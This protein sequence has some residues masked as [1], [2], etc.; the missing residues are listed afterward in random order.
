MV[1]EEVDLVEGDA[2]LFDGATRG[3]VGR[4]EEERILAVVQGERPFRLAV[5]AGDDDVGPAT[6]LSRSSGHKA[7][8]YSFMARA[9]LAPTAHRDFVYEGDVVTYT[10]AVVNVGTYTATNVVL[11]ETLPLYTNYLGIDWMPLNSR[12]F[13]TTLNSLAPGDGR[14]V[15][16][17]VR[18][19]DPIP[20][21]VSNLVNHVCGYSSDQDAHP[22]D[23]CHYEDTPVVVRPLRVSKSAPQCLAPGSD[24][25]YTINFANL[26]NVA[27]SN[28]PITDTLPTY[29]TYT[30]S[31]GWSC[32]AGI[33]TQIVPSLP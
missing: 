12:T 7:S 25:N 8:A 14:I 2:R 21:G 17:V 29:T 26:S 16:F 20:P 22:D 33:C 5:A 23:N 6:P 1:F 18:V 9:V 11:T 13:I 10:I 15:Y 3:E 27:F 30:G 24:F 19:Q 28:V 4:F 31:T 32:A